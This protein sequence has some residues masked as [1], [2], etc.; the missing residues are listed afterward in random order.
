LLDQ[1]FVYGAIPSNIERGTYVPLLV[2]ASYIVASF[3][4]YAGLT[5]AFRIS[6][7]ETKHQKRL[8]HAIGAFSF[9]LGIWSMHFIGMIAYKMRMAVHYDIVL[10][11]ISL[12][13]AVVIAYF[14][15]SIAR[16]KT[17][18]WRRIIVSSLLL[19]FG[20]CAMH[21]IGMAAM[22][23]RASLRYIPSLFVLSVVIAIVA[24]GAALWIIFTL[25]RSNSR[26][27]RIWT[28]IAAAIMGVA[29][30]GMHYT[31]MAASVFVPL[32]DCQFDAN[33]SFD[34]LALGIIIGNAILLLILLFSIS[35][36]LFLISFLAALFMCPLII[37][38]YQSATL[39][40]TEVHSAEKEQYGVYYHAQLMDLF[41]RLQE[42]RGLSYAVANGDATFSD[43]LRSRILS[44]DAVIT[45]VDDADH[46]YKNTL[47]VSLGWLRVKKDLLLLLQSKITH[48]GSDE[49]IQYSKVINSLASFMDDVADNSDLS[50]DSELSSDYLSIASINIVPKI[51]NT[52]G[53]AWGLSAGLLASG[54]NRTSPWPLEDTEELRGLNRELGFLDNNFL[55]DDLQR[56]QLGSDTSGQF[57][58][59]HDQVVE[60]KSGELQRY[61][62]K[63]IVGQTD[64]LNKLI[65]GQTDELSAPQIVKLG[66]DTIALYDTLYD[67]ISDSFLDLLKKRQQDYAIKR[68]LMLYSSLAAL[69]GFI[70]IFIFLYRSLSK[71]ESI[72]KEATQAEKQIKA[73]MDNVLEGIITINDRGVMQTF[74]AA[75]EKTFGYLAQEAIGQNVKMLM[76]TS[77]SDQHDGYL[78]RYLET[79][80]NKT[81][82]V[83]R[84]VI[85]LRKDGSQFPMM[86][87]VSE[88]LVD[89]KP[90]FIG[91][92]R[93]IT[94]KKE[95]EKELIRAK[96]VAEKAN[97]TKSEFLAN[98]S[99]ELRT[100]L[101][102]I[103]G[104][105]RLLKKS[106]L[107]QEES[108]MIDVAFHSSINL[109]DI[110]NDILDLSKIEAG[111][112][113]LEH[114]G[115]DINYI[116]NSA[117]ITF[118]PT[119]LEK[120][121]S[122]SWHNEKI[123]SRLF[124]VIQ[125]G[126]CEY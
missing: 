59:Y 67:R 114:I 109:L 122:L 29:I 75:A 69:I 116:I 54:H 33:Q 1:F 96:E 94:P 27:K 60:P 19:G 73:I 9:G 78:R 46:S 20:I 89:G 16:S 22:Q 52:V 25:G 115:M 107:T 38:I 11:I 92:A 110:V 49:F 113:H 70:V 111:E 36:R 39:L 97:L 14:A 104:M 2:L 105:L 32:A 58:I 90:L 88:I 45:S 74:N 120:N 71:T 61:L 12:V 77:F 23:M 103:M 76:P 66:N 126:S 31:G 100:P 68:D 3:S 7:A 72:Q 63:L 56:A 91:L 53:K 85:G 82:G 26:W 42:I 123:Y 64:D 48:S 98:M 84:E 43:T 62:D 37:I 87:G 102:S 106:K 117:V 108:G 30:C 41:E 17:F 101:N 99:H 119:A 80:E 51:I 13:I 118:T 121:L 28:V 112:M 125:P 40:D 21:Y 81:I 83:G 34:Q 65:V 18:V 8:L 6:L 50:T 47:N 86:L 5:L 124:L 24:S 35:G 95:K 15:L 4:S 55:K 93:D 57:I 10:T 44:L 79:G